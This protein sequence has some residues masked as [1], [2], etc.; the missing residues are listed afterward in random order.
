MDCPVRHR[1]VCHA[2]DGSNL[3]EL[4]DIMVHRHFKAGDS[5]FHQDETSQLFAIIVSGVVKLTRLLPDGRQQIVGLLSDADCLGNPFTADS[6]DE[7]ECVTD[8]ELCCFRRAHL[9][10]TGTRPGC[11][12]AG[13]RPAR[14]VERVFLLFLPFCVISMVLLCHCCTVW[15]VFCTGHANR[16]L[17]REHCW[18][19]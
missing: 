19:M 17:R 18:N 2:L 10:K 8:V 3:H 15:V 11:R 9:P 13:F 6:H 16:R 12:G 1:A 4:S 14:A 7:A 5:I